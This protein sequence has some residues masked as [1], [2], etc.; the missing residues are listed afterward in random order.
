MKRVLIYLALLFVGSGT[1]TGNSVGNID[2]WSG[3]GPWSVN[4]VA[5]AIDPLTPSTLYA[6]TNDAGVFKSTDAGGNWTDMNNG[7]GSLHVSTLA[8]DPL[9]PSTLYAGTSDAG[10]FK[11]TDAG[12]S[13]TDIN[14]GLGSSHVST[15]AIDPLTPSTLYVGASI[16]IYKSMDAG[17]RWDTMWQ[18][19]FLGGIWP[20]TVN[21]LAI[22]PLT[23]STIYAGTYGGVKKNTDGTVCNPGPCSWT[24]INNGLP[25]EITGGWLT[26][27]T[28][29]AAIRVLAVN[30][31]TPSTLYAGTENF[32]V[33]KS[34]DGGS[35]WSDMN[36]G[37]GSLNVGALVIDPLTP[38]TLY[39]G[40]TNGVYVFIGE[41]SE[42]GEGSNPSASN[43]GGCFII[44]TSR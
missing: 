44:T 14:N 30:P 29:P 27:V 26:K 15:L 38:S 18:G 42:G 6:G 11:S 1:M 34:L 5:L 13:W 8:V 16:N 12:M 25:T 20:E 40:T 32:G 2:E 37:L 21:T 19:Y 24:S 22:D 7:L 31:L 28:K 9:A 33:Y 36:N 17:R 39:S 23:P 35:S 41:N 10:V 3:C 43:G 4:I